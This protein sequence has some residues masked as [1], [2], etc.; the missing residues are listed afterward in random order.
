[1][2]TFNSF[3]L[4]DALWDNETVRL[5]GRIHEYKGMQDIYLAQKPEVLDRLRSTAHIK[6]ITSSNEIE[7]IYTSQQ[8]MKLLI[9]GADSP[10]TSDEEQILGYKNVLDTIHEH[11][12]AIPLNANYILQLHRD[13]Y[14]QS[15]K[16]IGGKFKSTENSIVMVTKDGKM[17][18]RFRP[19]S[20]IQTP[21]AIDQICL[22]YNHITAS[23]DVEDLLMIP[24][25][26]HDFLC[27][28][29]FDDG[30]GRLSRLLLDLLL[31]KSGY[32]I[33][34]YTSL[35]EKIADYKRE[36]YNT[37]ALSDKG[38]YENTHDNGPF[39]RFIL[40]IILA[41]YI[42]LDLKLSKDPSLSAKETVAETI[43][44]T[45]GRFTKSK[46]VD[47]LPTLGASTIERA[48]KELT[49]E[50]YIIKHGVGKS[51]YYTRN[52]DIY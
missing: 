3:L 9:E 27:I 31:L 25:F 22:Q 51:T 42:E 40:K 45:I 4:T 23:Q 33:S 36:Y 8:R 5:V 17:T 6:S 34:Q 46:L 12:E 37:I 47:Q 15:T 39:V 14:S 52:I 44:Q 20:P 10:K 7:G 32:K 35:E 49:E 41:A 48:L 18:E 21:S 50:H 11:Y 16:S 19:L 30:N 13:L 29:P 43:D 28:H 1:M 24:I 26:I 2:K 38:W